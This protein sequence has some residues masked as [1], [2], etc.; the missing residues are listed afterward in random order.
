M[1]KKWDWEITADTSNWSW[2]IRSLLSYRHLLGSLVRKNFIINYKQTV[3]GPAWI[4]LQPILTLFVYVLVFGK[5]IRV[6]TGDVPPPLFYLS[7]I[8]IW[9]FFNESFSATSRTFRDYIHIF[10]KVYFPRIIIPLSTISTQLM[11]FLVQFL[12]LVAMLAYYVFVQDYPM[13]VGFN[14][15]WVPVS[16]I[17]LGLTGLGLG[18]IFSVLTAKYRDISNIVDVGIRLLFFVT[19]VVYP[20]SAV[21]EDL[22]WL[23]QLNPLTP[24]FELFRLGM[25]GQGTVGS[26][27]FSA[28]FMVVVLGLGLHL[29]NRQGSKLIDVV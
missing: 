3:L 14:F 9:N 17:M 10:T 4:L 27:S 2:D 19:P 12:F 29:F 28:G 7:G 26:L 23:V 25:I 11:R 21:R 5:L 8:V 1:E 15:L 18:L 13:R 20:L 22:H 16:V 6:P 24:L